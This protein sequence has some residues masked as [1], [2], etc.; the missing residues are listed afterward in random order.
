MPLI[1]SSFWRDQNFVP[2]TE[3]FI[4]TKTLDLDASDETKAN[5]L[6]R[7]T[8][9]V[10][11]RAIYGIVTESLG[12]NVTAAHFRVNDGTDQVSISGGT[13]NVSSIV[14]GSVIVRSDRLSADLVASNATQT[15][16]V[17]PANSEVTNV[18]MPFVAIQKTGDVDTDIEFVYTTTSTPT[19]GQIA[20]Y[21]R[22]V[23]LSPESKLE[24]L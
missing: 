3:A 18:F 7:V 4:T 11:V 6:F 15:R 12:S 14:S 24:T 22:W 9:A 1:N 21:V 5:P 8:G 17:D 23:P 10:E 16:V 2:F 13:A 19:E 20:F